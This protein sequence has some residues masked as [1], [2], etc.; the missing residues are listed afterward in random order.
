MS[1]ENLARRTAV[2]VFFDGVDITKALSP[3]LLSLTYTDKEEDETDDLQIQ[4]ED[5]D[6]VWLKKWM[7]DA[8]QAASQSGSLGG[9]SSG[10]KQDEKKEKAAPPKRYRV[11][12]QGG[13][14]VRSRPDQTYT[15]YTVYGSLP[16]GSVVTP[17]GIQ[18]GWLNFTYS[19]K[20]A[21]ADL[22]AFQE[23]AAAPAPDA[24]GTSGAPSSAGSTADGIKIGDRVTVSGAPQISSYGG[25]P[26]APVTNYEGTVTYLNLRSGVPYP[27]CVGALGWFALDKIRRAG[28]EPEQEAPGGRAN[29]GLRIQAAI[30]CENWHG[31]GEDDVLS[32]GQYEL[33]NI[34]AQ[35]PPGTITLKGTSLPYRSTV[36]Q[37]AKSKSWEEYTL[38]GIGNEIAGK[39]GMT[40]MYL[41]GTN[42]FYKRVEQYRTSDICFLQKLCHD[43]GC[44]L[45]VSNN[46]IV[47]F[48]QASY[49]KKAAVLTIKRGESGNYGKYKISTRANSIYT[50]CHVS[51]TTPAG[52]VIQATVHTESYK[53]DDKKGQCLEIRQRVSSGAEAKT[54][55]EN[56]LRLHNKYEVTG[57]FDMPGAP[58]L[59]A[60]CT[61]ILEG[62]GTWDGKHVIKQ[63]KHS[64]SGSGYTT[65]ITVRIALAAN[66]IAKS[67]S[68]AG[69]TG[70]GVFSTGDKVM[71]NEG[72]R[73][74]Y[75]GTHMATWVPS[76]VLYVRGVERGGEVL[77]VS[78]EPEKNVYTGRVWA[79]DVHKI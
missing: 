28:G 5:R 40:C 3:Y 6:G 13:V 78:A 43:S 74:Y 69:E 62:W 68:P 36:R 39:N 51:Y 67:G 73:T 30:I 16:F 20:N 56:M 58:R 63:A 27:V 23:I 34:S 53:A 70:S 24:S 1:D 64:V 59:L 79:K 42:P 71:C 8:I 61:V 75:D 77:L 22:S 17:I 18:N 15:T 25:S 76:A 7:N 2:E 31:D 55:A 9:K 33:D 45:K 49:E 11:I 54:L 52:T 57:T 66:K 21:Y 32:C 46:I 12:A 60:G 4:L 35:G 47:I 10:K 72:V 26:G 19:G 29:K 37:V 48:D 41:S 14:N 38:S 50:S 44:S 65:Q